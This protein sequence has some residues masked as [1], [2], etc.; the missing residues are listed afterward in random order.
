MK[1]SWRHVNLQVLKE[2]GTLGQKPLPRLQAHKHQA[3]GMF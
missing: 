3:Q 1:R 2:G